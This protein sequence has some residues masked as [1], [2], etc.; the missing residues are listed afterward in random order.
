MFYVLYP[1]VA[2]LLTLPRMC[3]AEGRAERPYENH[4]IGA[5]L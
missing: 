5:R 3:V 2:Y 4:Y 1:L